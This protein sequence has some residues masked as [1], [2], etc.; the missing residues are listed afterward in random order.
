[1]AS[2]RQEVDIISNQCVMIRS[3][4]KSC[5]STD[6]VKMSRRIHGKGYRIVMDP[7]IVYIKK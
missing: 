3:R 7:C 6:S 1:M 5:M 2:L 4:L